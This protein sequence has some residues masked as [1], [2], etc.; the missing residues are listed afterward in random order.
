MADQICA[1]TIMVVKKG[2]VSFKMELYEVT[3]NLDNIV[4]LD[5]SGLELKST[6]TMN[7]ETV[8]GFRNSDQ[9]YPSHFLERA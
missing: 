9:T 6:Y 2:H 3:D 7:E 8:S 4:S 5:F 1:M